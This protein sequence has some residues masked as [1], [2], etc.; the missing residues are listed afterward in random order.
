MYQLILII[1][2]LVAAAVI[3]LV[4]IQHGKGADI[5]AAFGSGASNTVFGSQGTGSFLFKLTGGLALVFFVTSL[6][7]SALMTNQY[8]KAEQQLFPQQT[9]LPENKI[10]L[11]V[12]SGH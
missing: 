9:T 11:P 3:G 4:L 5:G 2:V 6:S 1:H 7:L 8:K 12:E 10:P